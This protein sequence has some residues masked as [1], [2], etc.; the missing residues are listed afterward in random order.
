M[1]IVVSFMTLGLSN[2]VATVT[3]LTVHIARVFPMRV[4]FILYVPL[5]SA[6]LSLMTS[7]LS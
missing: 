1:L 4:V 3:A 5:A 2:A 6:A 7:K